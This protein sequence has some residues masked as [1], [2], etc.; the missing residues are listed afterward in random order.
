M[1]WSGIDL[2]PVIVWGVA[3]GT[4]VFK[5]REVSMYCDQE[6]YFYLKKYE[7]VKFN[8]NFLRLNL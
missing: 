8:Q 2:E 3:Q 7:F 1:C 6:A 4:G 5:E